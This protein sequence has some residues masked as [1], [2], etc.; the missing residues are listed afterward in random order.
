MYLAT[1]F[2]WTKK[3]P[4]KSGGGGGGGGNNYTRHRQQGVAPTADG[5]DRTDDRPILVLYW[6]ARR[7]NSALGCTTAATARTKDQPAWRHTR[8][9]S[10]EH[11]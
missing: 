7:Y 8:K 10:E 3:V 2:G 11:A 1:C 6:E 5:E 4:G 9:D